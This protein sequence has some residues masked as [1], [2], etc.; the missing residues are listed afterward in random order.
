MHLPCW[1]HS[2]LAAC[3]TQYGPWATI[4]MTVTRTLQMKD[5]FH[6]TATN[7]KCPIGSAVLDKTIALHTGLE[8]LAHFFATLSTTAIW[9]VQILRFCGECENMIEM[10][11]FPAW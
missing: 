5:L 2:G 1:I 6:S 10:F 4:A 3:M 9:N 11:A 7:N 8:I